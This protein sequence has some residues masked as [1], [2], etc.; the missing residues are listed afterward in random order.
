M[1]SRVCMVA[2]ANDLINILQRYQSLK[3]TVIMK[4]SFPLPA[5]SAENT[6]RILL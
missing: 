4:M 1:G 6:L 5:T 3:Y 2:M